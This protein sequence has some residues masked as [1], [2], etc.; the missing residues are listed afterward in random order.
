[1]PREPLPH[2]RYHPDPLRTGSVISSNAQCL[3]CGQSRGYVYALA[4]YTEAEVDEETICP[5]CIADGSA[6][7]E[8]A[9]TFVDGSDLSGEISDSAFATL[10]ERT[11]G[12]AAWQNEAWRACCGDAAA[13]LGPAGRADLDDDLLESLTEYVIDEMDVDEEEAAEMVESLDRDKG[14]TAYLFQ[15]LHCRT[16]L[17]HVDFP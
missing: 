7:L 8:W 16:R 9:A 4:P 13:F 17:F 12:Y 1:V 11:P 5:W 2:F 14:P 10:T 6:A 15:C 3:R